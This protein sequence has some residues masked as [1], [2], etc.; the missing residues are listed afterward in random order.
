[1]SCQLDGLYGTWEASSVS[2]RLKEATDTGEAEPVSAANKKSMQEMHKKLVN[3]L[4]ENQ[5]HSMSLRREY[6]DP[7]K[8]K[9]GSVSYY[10][11]THK[12]RR[13]CYL[14]ADAL[15]SKIGSRSDAR[16]YKQSLVD[17]G[18]LDV[19]TGGTGG[20]RFVVER[21]IFTGKGKEGL[22]WVHAIKSPIKTS[23]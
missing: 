14:T 2:G 6:A 18:L 9:F 16:R 3:Y 23:T 20:R 19:S 5:A 8:H 4:I 13:Y 11:A 1:M 21:R 17:R 15:K 12:R 7:K 22:K 10:F